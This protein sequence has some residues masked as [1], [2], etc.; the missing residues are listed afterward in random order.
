MA[1][2]T[3]ETV[4]LDPR[5]ES[6][7][8]AKFDRDIKGQFLAG[9]PGGPGN[10]YARQV[11]G[12]RKALLKC[13]SAEQFERVA[14]K[15]ASLAEEGDLQAIKLL[16][17]YMM[18]KPMPA[19]DPDRVDVHE[20]QLM[21]DAAP[22]KVESA[23]LMEAGVPETHLKLLRMMRPLIA[24]LETSEY[25]KELDKPVETP[26]EREQR[27]KREAAEDAEFEE[28][29]DSPESELPAE[30]IERLWPSANGVSDELPSALDGYGK[31]PP[32]ANGK[33]GQSQRKKKKGMPPPSSNGRF[34]CEA[35]R[36]P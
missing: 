26:A 34:H 17:S 11:A 24:A 7:E 21:R 27:E 30:L 20:L 33:T 6:E 29:L 10:P 32:S 1:E 16:F 15:L 13:I 35:G 28:D 2:Q 3:A 8:H 5:H 19:A 31:R 22:L 12:L 36:A 25:M 9:N 18:G 4:Q 14:Q 23:Q